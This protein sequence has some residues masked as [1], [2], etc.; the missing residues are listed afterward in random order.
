MYKQLYRIR[1]WIPIPKPFIY[2]ENSPVNHTTLQPDIHIEQWFSTFFMQQ[3]I[4][5]PNLIQ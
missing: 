1:F 2:E 3:P 5:Q 4:L